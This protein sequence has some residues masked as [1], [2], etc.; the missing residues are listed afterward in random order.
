MSNI[1]FTPTQTFASLF[2]GTPPSNFVGASGS[3]TVAASI[4]LNAALNGTVAGTSGSIG[5]ISPDFTQI[6]RIPKGGAFPPVAKIVNSHFTCASVGGDSPGLC[7]HGFRAFGGD[8]TEWR[9]PE[10]CDELCSDD[11]Q[12]DGWLPDRRLHEVDLA[13][14][15]PRQQCG[16]RDL[17]VLRADL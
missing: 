2:G 4:G 12:P 3:E 5:Y 10:G 13:Y 15:L 17:S 14:V 9:S 1:S 11:T 7:R 16:K 6:A 8:L